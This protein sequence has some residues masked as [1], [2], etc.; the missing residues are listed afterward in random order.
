MTAIHQV[1][2]KQLSADHRPTKYYFAYGSNLHIKQMKRRCPNSRFIGRGRLVN[3]RWQINERG[4]ANV[5]ECN[6]HWVDGLVYEIDERDEAK[7]DINEGV[8]KNAYAKCHMPVLLYRAP[9][10]LYRRPVSWIV[11]KGGPEKACRQVGLLAQ[12]LPGHTEQWEND[13]LVYKSFNYIEDSEPKEEYINRINL[14]VAD[15]RE[16]GID[17]DYIRN[18]IR[19]Y[20]PEP[21]KKRA[22]SEAGSSR[23]KSTTRGTK[24]NPSL[25]SVDQSPARKG[26]S[27]RRS[28][29]FSPQRARAAS[30]PRDVDSA[31]SQTRSTHTPKPVVIQAP[32]PLP[33]RPPLARHFHGFPAISVE[34]VLYTGWAWRSSI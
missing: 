10:A 27:P 11:D 31:P 8:S 23:G 26:Q 30:R 15:A 22:A 20:I 25:Q 32:P 5:I 2:Q 28:D 12:C 34:D 19:P 29:Q 9:S 17:D 6:G 33:P 4:Y 14:G 7:L 21:P 13:V 16:L 1:L 24:R 18:C 3:Y